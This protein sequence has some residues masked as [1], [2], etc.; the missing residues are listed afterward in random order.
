VPSKRNLAQKSS[1]RATPNKTN[2]KKNRTIYQLPQV[3]VNQTNASAM[4]QSNHS[5]QVA[6]KHPSNAI[7][8]QSSF[9]NQQHKKAAVN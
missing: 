7:Q 1:D 3:S 6:L 9:L 4:L 5:S 8:T 2:K